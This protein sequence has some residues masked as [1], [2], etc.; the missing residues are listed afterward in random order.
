[1]LGRDAVHLCAI[2][3]FLR[4]PAQKIANLIEC[5]SEIPATANELQAAHMS[6]YSLYA[7]GKGHE[8]ELL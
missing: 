7:E 3:N 4:R 1:M 2:L 5:K 6:D 8:R